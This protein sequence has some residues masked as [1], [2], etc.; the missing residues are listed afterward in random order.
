MKKAGLFMGLVG[1]EVATDQELRSIGK[2][3]TTSQAKETIKKLREHDIATIGTFLIGFENDDEKKIKER[4]DFADQVDPDIFALHFVTPMPGSPVWKKKVRQRQIEPKDLDL[5]RWDL[6]HPVVP[7]K[8]LSVEE[9][10]RLGAWCS[11]EF[12]SRPERIHRIMEGNYS[13]LVKLCVKDFMSNVS[14]FERAAAA[15]EVYI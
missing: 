11:R 13:P 2:G 3:I 9:L 12:Y 7:T 14:N 10:G 5:R 15:G 8:H 4:F 6:Q 1:I